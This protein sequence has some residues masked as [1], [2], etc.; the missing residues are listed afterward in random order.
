[1]DTVKV[2]SDSSML[3]AV[4]GIAMVFAAGSLCAQVSVPLAAVKSLPL[5]L[6]AYSV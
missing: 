6:P 5:A 2:S 4:I 3:S 1:M